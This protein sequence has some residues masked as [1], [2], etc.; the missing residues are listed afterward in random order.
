MSE[1]VSISKPRSKRSQ[2]NK[3]DAFL[4]LRFKL[5]VG[6]KRERLGLKKLRVVGFLKKILGQ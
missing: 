6:I 2:K 1:G 5:I 4:V 3:L